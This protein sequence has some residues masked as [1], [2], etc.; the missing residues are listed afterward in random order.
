MTKERVQGSIE[1]L[2]RIEEQFNREV[3]W[4]L[5]YLYLEIGDRVWEILDNLPRTTDANIMREYVKAIIH[6]VE[7]KWFRGVTDAQK[8]VEMRKALETIKE[9]LG[10]NTRAYKS[11]ALAMQMVAV[12][13]LSNPQC[14]YEARRLFDLKAYDTFINICNNMAK[15]RLYDWRVV[16]IIYRMSQNQYV[17]EYTIQILMRDIL[18]ARSLGDYAYDEYI[19]RLL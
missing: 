12:D 15:C 1:V 16:D 7:I 19:T 4:E 13:R 14:L 11:C 2:R 17:F 6:S 9:Q 5:Y 3:A 10:V 8:L 18:R